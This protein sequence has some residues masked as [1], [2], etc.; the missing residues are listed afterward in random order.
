ME[1]TADPCTMPTLGCRSVLNHPALSTACRIAWGWMGCALLLGALVPQGASFAGSGLEGFGRWQW[2]VRRCERNLEGGAVAR[3]GKVQVDQVQEDV[4][5]VRFIANG[6]QRD[7]TNQLTFV[8]TVVKGQTALRCR[9]ALCQP[10][11]GVQT[12]VSSVSERFFDARGVAE[13]LPKAWPADGSCRVEPTGV[14]CEA[15]ALTG[16]RWRAEATI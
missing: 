15:K 16:E 1:P 13:G 14:V 9:D 11:T 4:L 7:G 3:C 6:P 12:T 10:V 8:G 5:S 2:D